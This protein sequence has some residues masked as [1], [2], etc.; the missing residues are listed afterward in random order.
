MV[1]EDAQNRV[2]EYL[3]KASP[4]NTFRLARDLG[5]ISFTNIQQLEKPEFLDQKVTCR[6]ID[7]TKL[8]KYIQNLKV[9][10]VLKI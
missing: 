3:K 7:F 2:F 5:V 4:I 1:I 6:K 9:P 10:D 8:N